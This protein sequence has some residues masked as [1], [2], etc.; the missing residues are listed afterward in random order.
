MSDENKT[1]EPQMGWFKVYVSGQEVAGGYGPY[2]SVKRE[3]DHYAMMYQTD[4]K[5]RIR[6][7]RVGKRNSA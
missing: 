6:V 1:T 3:A 4:G 7:Q 5:V 2:E